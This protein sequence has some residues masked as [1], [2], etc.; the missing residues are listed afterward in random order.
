M[1]TPQEKEFCA[2]TVWGAAKLSGCDRKHG[3]L[4]IRD[5]GRGD[6]TSRGGE[7]FFGFN[8]RLTLNL[9]V[10]AILGVLADCGITEAQG[11][12][13]FTTKFPSFVDMAQIITYGISV[14]YFFGEID[15][16]EA[17]R[18]ANEWN[19]SHNSLEIVK[20]EVK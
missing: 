2:A 11:A 20:L 8:R 14:V 18:L 10:S 17:V 9:E 19:A 4:V 13:L 15:D 16:P 3:A 12:L 1:L 7:L 5:H 6:S